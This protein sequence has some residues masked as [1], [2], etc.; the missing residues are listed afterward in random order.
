MCLAATVNGG[1]D[2]A[3]I[4][5]PTPPELAAALADQTAST[6]LS[7]V[8]LRV[9]ADVEAGARLGDGVRVGPYCMIGSEV[10]SATARKWACNSS[11]LGT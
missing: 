9:R 6:E 4:T 1:D 5:A 10:A 3:P 11:A 2:Y 7:K 8:L